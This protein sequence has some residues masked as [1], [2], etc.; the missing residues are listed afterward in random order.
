[1]PLANLPGQFTKTV[2][3][4]RDLVRDQGGQDRSCTVSADLGRQLVKPFS[5]A[6]PQCQ[7]L[8]F[9]DHRAASGNAR[10]MTAACSFH[11]QPGL[12]NYLSGL[13]IVNLLAAPGAPIA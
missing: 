4:V 6:R 7:Q 1:M 9:G 3:V 2:A 10:A 8:L 11:L 5:D 12:V 13:T